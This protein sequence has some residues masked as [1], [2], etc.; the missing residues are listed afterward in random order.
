MTASEATAFICDIHIYVYI[1]IYTYIYTVFVRQMTAS[2]ATAFICDIVEFDF[3]MDLSGKMKGFYK[4][5][6]EVSHSLFILLTLK[7][8]YECK[9]ESDAF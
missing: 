9:C 5:L 3:F 7:S 8:L 1:Y 4:K 6:V 2:E